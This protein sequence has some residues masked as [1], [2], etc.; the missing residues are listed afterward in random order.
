M[1]SQNDL[2]RRRF[3]V[4]GQVQGVGFRPFVYRIATARGLVGF[5]KNAPAG[6]LIETQGRAHEVA[7]FSR[8]LREEA[9]PLARI[10]TL[11]ETAAPVEPPPSKEAQSFQIVMSEAGAGHTVRISPD[12]AVCADCLED[13]AD[14]ENPRHH[15]PFTNCTNCGPRYTITRSIPYD[16]PVTSMACFPLCDR[17]AAEY[18]DPLDRRFHAQPNAC[19]LCG[20]RL[21]LVE[22][23]APDALP[24]EA[25][26]WAHSALRG[27]DALRE[28]AQRLVDGAVVAIKGLGGFHLAC[29]ATNPEAV[30]ALRTRKARPHKPLAVMVAD[31]KAARVL[32]H[33]DDAAAAAM[34]GRA[35]PIVVCPLRAPAAGPALAPGVSPDT[36]R[37]G[38]MTPYTPLHHVLFH[39]LRDMGTPS[40]ALVMTSGNLSEEPIALGNREA[41]RRLA[42]I[43]DCFLLH[44]RD[45]LIRTDDSVVAAAAPKEAQ[46]LGMPAD[47]VQD[48]G[49]GPVAFVFLRRA[50]GFTPSPIALA[51]LPGQDAPPALGVGPELKNTICLTKGDEAY[52][53]QHI[54]DLE[55]LETFGFFRET[56]AHLE[57]ILKVSPALVVHDLHPDF[58]TTRWAREEAGAP[59][60]GVQHHVAHAHAV[61]A[62]H[63]MHGAAL[64]LALDGVG[65]GEDGTLWGGEC[66]HVDT[67]SL[68]HERLG[69]FTPF[70]LPGGDAAVKAPWRIAQ[71]VLHRLGE[72]APRTRPWP[73][74]EAHAAASRMTAQLLEK[75][76]NSP[77]TSSCGRLF[78]AV[79]A[80]LG[81]GDVVSYEGQAA[82]RLEEAQA[83]I[84]LE[85][86]AVYPC[87]VIEAN[88]ARATDLLT[89]RPGDLDV[90]TLFEALHADWMRDEP[91]A[92]L[93]RR[94]HASLVRG[95][96]AW[97]AGHAR[98][99]G[100][101]AVGLSGG[102]MQ[103]RTLREALPRALAAHGLTP[104]SHGFA[105]PNDGCIALGQA[106]WGRLKLALEG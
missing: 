79:A 46:T 9:P 25:T 47:A 8:A 85:E 71:A 40:P 36:G 45:I 34:A 77:V 60:F 101:T 72:Q 104:L 19:P 66:L 78:D 13:M 48:D 97:A 55:N 96:A 83:G 54:G 32:A 49:A 4:T 43:A 37:V 62:E 75:R 80:L 26:A 28:T 95:L 38:L 100:V 12:T 99:R 14:P 24:T 91:T 41:L 7:D 31:V 39:C 92:L 35:R 63:R 53:S 20:P 87:P 88:A 90:H 57:D 68:A 94:F 11:D 106:A 86:A 93:A 89:P 27:L 23:R 81:L 1:D 21:W 74:L 2:T 10:A 67:R 61:L 18:A 17:C 98:Q 51:P 33:V 42:A 22:G 70:L 5:V 56:V 50:R 58:M 15:Y 69:R 59:A 65:L 6:V 82:I 16:R 30:A 44:D 64:C 76:I 73:W 105:P 52:L 84:A 3:V 102:V 29:D 103:N